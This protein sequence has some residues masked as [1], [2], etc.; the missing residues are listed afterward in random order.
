MVRGRGRGDEWSQGERLNAD[1]NI[2]QKLIQI[3]PIYSS[4]PHRNKDLSFL[5]N[6]S[7]LDFRIRQDPDKSYCLTI[8]PD[9]I[10]LVIL[11]IVIDS[12]NKDFSFFTNGSRLNS[13]I[14]Q[15]PDKSEHPSLCPSLSVIQTHPRYCPHRHWSCQLL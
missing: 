2:P 10:P 9:G 3:L 1:P 6:S 5:T 14:Q 11:D 8:S 7:R 12:R 13:S 4:S 15:D